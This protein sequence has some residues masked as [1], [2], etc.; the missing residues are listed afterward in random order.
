MNDFLAPN[1][2]SIPIMVAIALLAVDGYIPDSIVDDPATFKALTDLSLIRG[3]GTDPR[4]FPCYLAVK[5]LEEMLPSYT[6]LIAT[7]KE[8]RELWR[9]APDDRYSDMLE[10]MGHLA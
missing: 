2:P 7:Y 8:V 4:H 9:T 3:K 5:E 1:R 6:R 10:M